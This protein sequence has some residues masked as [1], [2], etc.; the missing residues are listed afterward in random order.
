M[1]ISVRMTIH[2]FCIG[3]RHLHFCTNDYHFFLNG[4]S[5][6]TILYELLSF[7]FEWVFVMHI[8][9]RMT[10]IYFWMDFR[11]THFCTNDYKFFCIDCRHANFCTNDYHFFFIG[12]SSC[13]FLYEFLP[14]L[15]EWIVVMHI[16]VRMTTISFSNGCSSCTFLY[17]WL[18]FRCISVFVMHI[19]CK[20]FSIL[21]VFGFSSCTF[22]CEWLSIFF[23]LSMCAMLF[24][25]WI[26]WCSDEL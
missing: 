18:P 5:S 26:A 14:F 15:F 3:F 12:F 20:W 22:L 7:L 2:F 1:H 19:L 21:F 11:H 13:T 6:C 9:V 10:V 24:N 8:Y 4:L 25:A 17:K 16:S 23:W